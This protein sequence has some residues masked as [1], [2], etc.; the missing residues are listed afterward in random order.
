VVVTPH[1]GWATTAARQRL[2]SAAVENYAAFTQGQRAN[3]VD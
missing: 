1:I 3:R 2:V